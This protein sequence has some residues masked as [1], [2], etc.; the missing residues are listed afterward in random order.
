MRCNNI[1]IGLNQLHALIIIK[2]YC[3]THVQHC[4]H[5]EVPRYVAGVTATSDHGTWGVD[6]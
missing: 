5:V 3:Y 2:C 6:E 4:R 1:N